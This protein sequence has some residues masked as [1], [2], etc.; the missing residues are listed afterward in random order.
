MRMLH[1]ESLAWHPLHTSNTGLVLTDRLGAEA[2]PAIATMGTCGNPD[3][4]DYIPWRETVVGP[5]AEE[6]GVAD[7]VWS[8]VVKKWDPSMARIES[9]MAARSR[10]VAVHVDPNQESPASLME[11][12]LLT[13]GGILRG[14]HVIVSMNE[15]SGPTPSRPRHLARLA[16]HAT[17]EAFPAL[18]LAHNVEQLAHRA[19]GV[20]QSIVKQQTAGV[21]SHVEHIMPRPQHDLKPVINL[22]GTSGENRPEWLDTVTDIIGQLD[23]LQGTTST[24]KDSYVENWNAEHAQYEL[25]EKLTNAV[26]LIGITGATESLGALAEL[27]PRL[28]HGHL[29]GQ[30]IGVYIEMHDSSPKSAT[31]RTRKLAKEHLARLREDFPDLPVFVADNLGELAVFGISEL[32]KQK[33]RLD[34]S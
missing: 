18:T 3:A 21:V 2:V 32:N 11:A 25:N 15:R 31:N 4:P 30:S 12:G 22:A 10:V 14:Q 23:T 5:I 28:L 6:Y 20:L 33:Q 16:L 1:P 19:C 26:Q 27:G 24:V 29:A 17:A 13:Y 34:R 8:P 9:I 7:N